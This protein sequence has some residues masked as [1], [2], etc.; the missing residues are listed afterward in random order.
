MNITATDYLQNLKNKFDSGLYVA[1]TESDDGKP[2]YIKVP[3]EVFNLEKAINDIENEKSELKREIYL[4][5]ISL[6]HDL[7]FKLDRFEGEINKRFLIF[8]IT[9][10]VLSVCHLLPAFL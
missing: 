7:K 4:R 8:S 2:C 9:F 5:S 1:K 10:A 6:T 3:E